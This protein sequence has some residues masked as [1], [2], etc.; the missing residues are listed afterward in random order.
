MAAY[1]S[2]ISLRKIIPFLITFTLVAAIIFFTSASFNGLY[3]TA[4]EL[5][6]SGENV[7]IIYGANAKTPQTSVIPLPLYDKVRSVEGVKNV[8]PE[9]V[10]AAL[11]GDDAI[12]VRGVDPESFQKICNIKIVRGSFELSNSWSAVIGRNLARLLKVD[13]GDLITLRSAFTYSFLEVKILGVFESGS[14]LD[15][16]LI[17][18]IYA[19]QWLRGLPRDAI[20]LL[21]VEIDGEKLSK[22]DLLLSL[23]GEKKVEEK[24]PIE[25]PS[26]IRLLTIPEAREHVGEY[27]AR[28]PEESMKVFLEKN[29]RIN[30]AVVWGIVILVISGCILLIYL[31]IS[32]VFT[33]HSREL[34]ILSSLGAS[35]KKLMSSLTALIIAFSILSVTLGLVLGG[36]LSIVFSENSLLLLGSYTVKPSLSFDLIIAIAIAVTV[37]SAVSAWLGLSKLLDEWLREV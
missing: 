8:S 2:V 37:I 20:S 24:Q 19:V 6:G 1:I 30:E 16:E 11:V 29:V 3:Q 26:I 32:L 23:R 34:A 12:I 9:V 13:V 36:A 18:P 7:L 14:S 35:K 4:I 5:M 17:L 28:S 10:A 27:V 22:E 25:Q 33:S 31:A 15:D 21:R